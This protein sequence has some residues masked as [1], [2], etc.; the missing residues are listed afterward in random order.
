V[1]GDEGRSSSSSF[2]SSSFL[3]ELASKISTKD[4]LR[5]EKEKESDKD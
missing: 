5:E 3:R 1:S 2:A 4:E